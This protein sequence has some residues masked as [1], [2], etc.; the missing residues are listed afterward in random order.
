M[1]VLSIAEAQL[2]ELGVLFIV[3]SAITVV[4]VV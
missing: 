2:V 3:F 4:L 1:I